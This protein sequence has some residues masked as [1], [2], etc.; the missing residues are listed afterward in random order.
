MMSEVA[1]Q[2]AVS[3]QMMSDSNKSK[4]QLQV[5]AIFLVTLRS[6]NSYVRVV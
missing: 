1:G 4:V 5:V 3:R 2:W 6:K